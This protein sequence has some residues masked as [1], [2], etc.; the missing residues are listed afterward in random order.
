M[1][2]CIFC[3]ANNGIDPDFFEA[4]RQIGRMIGRGGH[5]LVLGGCDMG[6]MGC[7]AE[8]TRQNGGQTLGVVPRIIEEGGRQYPHLDIH[9]PCDNLADRKELLASHADA[10]VAMPGGVGTL[11]EI[12][13]VLAA[14]SIG[15]H[16]KRVVLLNLKG[17]WN[18]LIA[19]LRD[20]ESRG[21]TRPGL[22]QTIA[23]ADTVEQL[24]LMLGI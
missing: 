9:I 18:S 3:S 16:H 5:T 7:L 6:L 21:A 22:W 11:D 8:A 24:R 2:I 13:T 14:A 1:R 15:Y 10:I 12:F 23:V 17:Y 4:G 20:L 19:M